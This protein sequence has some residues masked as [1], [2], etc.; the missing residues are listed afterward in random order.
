MRRKATL[1]GGDDLGSD[2]RLTSSIFCPECLCLTFVTPG[3]IICSALLNKADSVCLALRCWNKASLPLPP[4]VCDS[5]RRIRGSGDD[6]PRGTEGPE[7]YGGRCSPPRTP[8]PLRF[9]ER[10]MKRFSCSPKPPNP[11]RTPPSFRP[12][13]RDVPLDGALALTGR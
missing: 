9:Y 12:V 7:I 3:V 5:R 8:R 2:Y 4:D 10:E 13:L 1:R 6:L 11:V